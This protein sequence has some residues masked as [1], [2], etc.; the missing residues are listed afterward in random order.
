MTEP[1]KTLDGKLIAFFHQSSDLYGSDKVLLD[2]ATGVKHLGGH[3]VVMLPE[4][5]LLTRELQARGIEYHPL[6]ILKLSR[7][8]FSPVGIFKLVGQVSAALRAYDRVFVNRRVHLVHSNTI[9]VLGGAVW[10]RRR[11]I[12]HLWHVHEIVQSPRMVARLLPLI[13]R[14]LADRIVCNSQATCDWLVGRQP[15]LEVKTEVVLNG[16]QPP[17]AVDEK[18]VAALRGH[19]LPAGSILAIGLVGRINRWKGQHLLMDAADLLHGRGVTNFSIVFCGSAPLGQEHFLSNL[20]QRIAHS[21]MHERVRVLP[22][23]KD[24]WPVYAALDI[25]CV[26]ST[27][28]EPFGLVA[29]EAMA[30]GKPL[31]VANHG[32]LTEIVVDGETGL[33]VPPGDARALADALQELLASADRRQHM[34]QAGKTRFAAEF[35]LHRMIG[36][37]A[38]LWPKTMD[39]YR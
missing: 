6:Q 33:T 12:P 35:S 39:E 18:T 26:P 30:M 31:V 16:V 4:L 11:H 10:A 22:F 36:R 3:A 37:F 38:Y 13:V 7:S 19:F 34:G 1:T 32:G 15:A 23:T 20:E 8:M 9:A 14:A 17:P 29:V 21:P 24:I 5:G 28:P 2:L 25:A 27:E